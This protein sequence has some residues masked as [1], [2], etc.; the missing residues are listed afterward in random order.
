MVGRTTP[1]LPSHMRAPPSCSHS[2]WIVAPV[3]LVGT[4]RARQDALENSLLAIEM[5]AQQQWIVKLFTKSSISAKFNKLEQAPLPWRAGYN[6][7]RTP[8]RR[9]RLWRRL[10]VRRHPS[11]CVAVRAMQ[12]L[13]HALDRLLEFCGSVPSNAAAVQTR[14]I[15]VRLTPKL[16]DRPH[17]YAS[18]GFGK[19]R[20]ILSVETS[21]Q[22]W[23]SA[24]RSNV[25][26]S[27]RAR[28]RRP[29]DRPTASGL[30]ALAADL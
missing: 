5:H 29:T 28:A 8:R 17:G 27:A 26:V 11:Q 9:G 18:R 25:Q 3:R 12:D 13:K 16:A 6:A 30:L 19:V 10:I 21:N 22:V 23:C 1:T 15:S 14:P 2:D 24:G 7:V 20:A 4:F